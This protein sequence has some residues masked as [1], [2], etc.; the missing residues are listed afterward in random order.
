MQV[1]DLYVLDLYVFYVYM[2][3]LCFLWF[4]FPPY[5]LLQTSSFAIYYYN[6]WVIL[7]IFIYVLLLR[8]PFLWLPNSLGFTLVLWVLWKWKWE[9]WW[10]KLCNW[11]VCFLDALPHWGR[12]VVLKLMRE[13]AGCVFVKISGWILGGLG[14]DGFACIWFFLLSKHPYVTI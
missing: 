10:G 12:G 2:P 1:S 4:Y 8:C 13:I 6:N 3:C 9:E 11:V 14:Y 7:F 5:T